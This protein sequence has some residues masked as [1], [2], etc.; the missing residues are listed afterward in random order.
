MHWQLLVL[1]YSIF[2]RKLE[3]SFSSKISL[4]ARFSRSYQTK[5][6]KF[7][8]IGFG[9]YSSV[10]LVICDEVMVAP[11]VSCVG[12]DHDISLSSSMRF[13]PRLR[14]N[15]IVLGRGSW[16]GCNV[17][18]LHGVEIAEGCVVGA[19]SVVTKNTPP[20]SVVCGN[21][22]SVIRYRS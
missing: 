13:A 12:G 20:N 14:A 7:A 15:P 4:G 1:I 17:V 11:R 21:P 5:I 22:A 9:F 2:N 16:I 10:P 3:S 19:G 6:G 8:Y 18:I